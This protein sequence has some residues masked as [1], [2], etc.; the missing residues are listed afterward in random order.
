MDAWSRTDVHAL[1]ALLKED[2]DSDAAFARVVPRARRVAR[3]F[4][5]Y[6]FRPARAAPARADVGEPAAGIRRLPG[7]SERAPEPFA[8]EVLR[9]ENGLIAEIDYFLQPEL[10]SGSPSRRRMSCDDEL[11]LEG[12]R[13]LPALSR[14]SWSSRRGR[15][16]EQMPLWQDAIVFVRPG[17]SSSSVSAA[18]A[19]ASRAPRSCASHR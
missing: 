1:A 11:D 18:S 12:S 2:V 14:R 10:S 5:A 16:S 7:R 9:I 6:P 17:R 3:F 15:S 13:E 4:A 19:G 8:V